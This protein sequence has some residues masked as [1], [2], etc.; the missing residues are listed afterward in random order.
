MNH[1]K[2]WDHV[3]IVLL[4]AAVV[5]GICIARSGASPDWIGRGL[6]VGG[7]TGLIRRVLP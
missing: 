7:L 1:S 3:D 5:A 2:P 6:F 4:I